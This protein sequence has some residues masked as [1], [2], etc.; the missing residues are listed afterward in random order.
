[1]IVGTIDMA[2]LETSGRSALKLWLMTKFEVATLTHSFVI[3]SYS[4]ANSNLL[5]LL[6]EA[7]TSEIIDQAI[8]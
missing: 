5:W 7:V 3:E 8:F 6:R 2:R 4:L 1:M